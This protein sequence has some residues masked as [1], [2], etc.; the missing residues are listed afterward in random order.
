VRIYA[1]ECERFAEQ[2]AGEVVPGAA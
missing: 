1:D 2:P